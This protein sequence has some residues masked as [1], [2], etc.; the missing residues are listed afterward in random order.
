[1]NRLPALLFL[2]ALLSILPGCAEFG[3]PSRV[4]TNRPI[5]RVGMSKTE[6]RQTYGEPSKRTFT[7]RGEIWIYWLQRP[8]LLSSFVGTGE[9]KTA[10]FVFDP[11]GTVIDFHFN[12]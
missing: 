1:M 3:S 2:A 12:E 7:S 4:D 5:P 11:T 8:N 10:G 9:S 6:V